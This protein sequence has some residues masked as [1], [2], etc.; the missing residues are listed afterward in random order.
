[1]LGAFYDSA[2]F[3]GPSLASP[4][5]LTFVDMARHGS[6]NLP[7]DADTGGQVAFNVL[8]IGP[9]IP[10]PTPATVIL[11]APANGSVSQP[12]TL[13]LTWATA[14]NAVYYR[15]QVATDSTFK[16]SSLVANDSLGASTT[17]KNLAG[18]KDATTYYWRVAVS[19][20]FGFSYYQ[21]PAWTF[22]TVVLTLNTILDSPADNSSN[23]PTNATLTWHA[24]TAGALKYQVQV[25]ND[26]LFTSLV[27]NDS[28]LTNPATTVTV[29]NCLKY[30]WRVRTRNS[31]G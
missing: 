16:P 22:T 20:R 12:Q 9:K 24:S 19:T 8:L 17:S 10:P 4:A 14:P 28:S 3:V 5:P 11:T 27:V 13:T 30:F 23:I 29:A 1:V 21:N 15:L 7:T 26:S 31:A 25:A 6:Y 2:I 18:L